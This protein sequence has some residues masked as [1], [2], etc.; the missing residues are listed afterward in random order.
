MI[1]ALTLDQLRLFVRVAEDGSFSAAGKRLGRVQ[2]AVGYGITK[3]ED[4]LGV[5]VFDRS[6]RRPV[7]SEAGRSLLDDARRVLAQLTTLHT[8]ANSMAGGLEAG[9]SVAV[10]AMFPSALLV[11]LCRQ[12]QAKFDLVN[13]QLHSGVLE[14]IPELV[15]SGVCQ[16]G[17]SSAVAARSPGLRRRFLTD[18]MLVPVAAPSHPLGNQ[19]APIP[20][21]VARDHVQVVISSQASSTDADVAVLSARQWRVAN[22][23]TKLALIEAGLGWGTLPWSLVS[24]AVDRGALVRLT[25]E[26]WGAAGRSISLSSIVAEAAPP[27]PAGRWLLHQL[28]EICA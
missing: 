25:M 24:D 27:G 7:L 18:V 23:T 15:S 19:P 10:S 20:T 9:V 4:H 21:S 13:L 22:V 2:S 26:A 28:P 12:F 1:E 14:A 8:R 16:L 11:A 3:M 6:G 5:A 17:I